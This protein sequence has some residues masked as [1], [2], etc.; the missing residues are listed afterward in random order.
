MTQ[1]DREESGR[2]EKALTFLNTSAVPA[3]YRYFLTSSYNYPV[4]AGF[5]YLHLMTKKLGT[6]ERRQHPQSF[7]AGPGVE[8]GC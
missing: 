2:V 1:L 4:K 8:L 3:L 5:C 7:T 6:R